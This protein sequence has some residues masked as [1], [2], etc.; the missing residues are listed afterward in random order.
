MKIT[1]LQENLKHGLSLV[2]RAASLPRV[3]LPVLSNILVATPQHSISVCFE[4]LLVIT[5]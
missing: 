1:V 4:C 5:S 3:T 2:S